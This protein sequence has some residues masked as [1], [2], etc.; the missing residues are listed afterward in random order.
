MYADRPTPSKRAS[1]TR[2]GLVLVFSKIVACVWLVAAF[3]LAV[4]AEGC[5]PAADL[6]AF[7][8]ARFVSFGVLDVPNYFFN[9]VYEALVACGSLGFV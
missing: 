1:P 8:E 6:P 5:A 7:I 4:V 3:F 2:G 9:Q